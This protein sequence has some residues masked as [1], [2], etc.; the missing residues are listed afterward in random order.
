MRKISRRTVSHSLNTNKHT[1]NCI[2]CQEESIT[3]SINKTSNKNRKSRISVFLAIILAIIW[4]VA[5]LKT[6]N[7]FMESVIPLIGGELVYLLHKASDSL[8]SS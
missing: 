5:A 7:N 6:Q 4:I 8:T 3:K 2:A 1:S